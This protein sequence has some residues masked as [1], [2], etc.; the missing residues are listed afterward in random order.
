MQ[1]FEGMGGAFVNFAYVLNFPAQP[2]LLPP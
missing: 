1:V 2:F